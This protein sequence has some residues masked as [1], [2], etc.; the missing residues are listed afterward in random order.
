MRVLLCFSLFFLL[1]Q[2]AGFAQSKYSVVLDAYETTE[3]P[4]SPEPARLVNQV[5]RDQFNKGSLVHVVERKNAA[6]GAK[7]EAA[8]YYVGAKINSLSLLP[9]NP[10]RISINMDLTKFSNK[11]ILVVSET[12]RIVEPKVIDAGAKLT[13]A[14]FDKSEYGRALAELSRDAVKA[15]EAKVANLKN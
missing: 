7:L 3:K 14:D 10:V 9:T 12:A 1:S 11:E 4:G 6:P 13:Q 8:P 15:F 5:L 2:T